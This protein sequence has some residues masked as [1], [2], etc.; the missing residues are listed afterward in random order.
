M[1]FHLSYANELC[2]TAKELVSAMVFL[3][4]ELVSDKKS[5]DIIEI[6]DT[7]NRIFCYNNTLQS[8]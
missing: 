3:D 2:G 8:S 7:Q 4:F 6:E 5:C 1:V